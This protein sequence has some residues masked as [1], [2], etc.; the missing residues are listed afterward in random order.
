MRTDRTRVCI[1]CGLRISTPACPKCR[2]PVLH[3]LARRGKSDA[4][5]RRSLRRYQ[6]ELRPVRVRPL[7]RAIDVLGRVSQPV[8]LVSATAIGAAVGGWFVFHQMFALA[9]KLFCAAGIGAWLV[10]SLASIA[11]EAALET[12]RDGL[13]EPSPPQLELEPHR[14]ID[15]SLKRETARGRVRVLEAVAAPLSGERCAAFRLLGSGANGAIDDAGAGVFELVSADGPVR[16]EAAH[17]TVELEDFGRRKSL[18]PEGALLAFLRARAAALS[19]GQV[20]VEEALL[21]DGDEVIV[22]G[23]CE[24]AP[25]G[26]GY[27]E[28]A[29]A[30]VFRELPGSPLVIRRAT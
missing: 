18:V 21:R 22:E 24:L 7:S 16:V 12:R 27:R 11:V 13:L 25:D 8:A 20:H 6:A 15:P 19:P 30:R 28:S 10:L 29:S 9:F 14:A 26:G 17:A 4:T 3:D 23:T 5:L 2:E 1:P